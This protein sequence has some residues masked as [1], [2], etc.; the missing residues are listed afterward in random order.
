MSEQ[1]QNTLVDPGFMVDGPNGS[2][3]ADPSKVPA[4]KTETEK[5]TSERPEWLDEKFKS[6]EDLAKA[7]KELEQKL[8]QKP[9]ADTAK[10]ADAITPE[11][12]KEKGFDMAA[13][14]TEYAEKGELSAETLAKLEEKGITKAAVDQY[15]EGVNAKAQQVRNEFAQLAGGEESLT[16]VLEWAKTSLSAEEA[17]GYDA[18]LESGNHAAAK[19]A[20]Q[21]IVARYVAENG[22][23]PT[24]VEAA[25]STRTSGEK[26][27]D[28]WEQVTKEMGKPEYQKDPAFRAKIARR[29][30]VSNL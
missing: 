5:S 11:Q 28:S 2:V 22:E 29:L 14:Q 16:S 18:L 4:P 13:L 27:F 10:P 17:A 25:P 24:L 9:A 8:G 1:N 7:Y 3:I 26:P 20:F 15:I 21:G 19:M 6:P 30:E 23:T 12:V